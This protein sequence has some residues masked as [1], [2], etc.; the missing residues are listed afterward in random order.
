[1]S[2]VVCIRAMFQYTCSLNG[3]GAL[4]SLADLFTI[5]QGLF[6]MGSL[7]NL[8][9]IQID[10]KRV[11]MMSIIAY[12]IFIAAGFTLMGNISPAIVS[13]YNIVI[14]LY[15]DFVEQ[16]GKQPSRILFF[17]SQRLWRCRT[18]LS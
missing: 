10:K 16:R 13:L 14:I 17:S 5:E 1:M 7:I 12:S 9:S 8:I 3:E 15:A 6:M 11:V 2:S 18:S 4:V